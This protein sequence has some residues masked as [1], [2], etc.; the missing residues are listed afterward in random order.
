MPENVI[1]EYGFYLPNGEFIANDRGDGHAKNAYRFCQ[2]YSSLEELM[3]KHTSEKADDLLIM[4]GCAAVAG[5][6]G[7]RCLRVAKDNTNPFIKE[8]VKE[9]AKEYKNKGF[10]IH[11]FWQIYTVF[12]QAL[13][14]VMNHDYA[15]ETES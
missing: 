5:S 11:D 9:L 13:N 14:H 3:T 2:K 7:E 8:L 15:K 12:A 10:Q 1:S 6:R 4:G